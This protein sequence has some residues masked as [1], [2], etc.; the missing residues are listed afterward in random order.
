MPLYDDFV[1]ARS[2]APETSRSIQ[3]SKTINQLVGTTPVLVTRPTGMRRLTIR[4][5][6]GTVR[7][8]PGDYRGVSFINGAIQTGADTI[9]IT[10]HGFET[11]QGPFQLTMAL[12]TMVPLTPIVIGDDNT[13]T[14]TGGSW[15]VDGFQPSVGQ[16]FTVSG[17]ASN[18]GDF[19]II[20]MTTSVITVSEDI[21]VAEGSQTDLTITGS[22]ESPT[23]LDVLTDF[24]VI[25]DTANTIQVAASL[26]D[27]LA[28][29][30]VDLVSSGSGL[31]SLGAPAGWAAAAV[32]P[33]SKADGYGS[34]A[35]V[36]EDEVCLAAPERITLVGMSAS[37]ACS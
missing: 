30:P 7:V 12:A 26:A 37:D 17:S 6:S 5:E 36:A 19:T 23:G 27:A 22:V 28:E 20:G 35:I 25:Y 33:A 32:A 4:C 34:I 14:R 8:R 18:D 16:V 29:S 15:W 3:L 10:G 24:W 1:D 31:L 13:F 2:I 21:T 9:A 11:G